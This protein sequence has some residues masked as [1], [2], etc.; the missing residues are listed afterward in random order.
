HDVAPVDTHAAILPPF[1]IPIRG[2]LV[3]HLVPILQIFERGTQPLAT[4]A[5]P[6]ALGA[7]VGEVHD[8]DGFAQRLAAFISRTACICA[9][10]VS[11]SRRAAMI[12]SAIRSGLP[13]GS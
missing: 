7:F 6:F 3:L 1:V 12:A 11:P 9:S 10:R 13:S 8:D 5:M 2:K 4:R